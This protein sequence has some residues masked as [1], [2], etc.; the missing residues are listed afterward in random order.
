[1][2]QWHNRV[3]EAMWRKGKTLTYGGKSFDQMEI[4]LAVD[5]GM[6]VDDYVLAQM[7]IIRDAHGD[8]S[9][10]PKQFKW[11][12]NGSLLIPVYF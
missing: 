12:H 4:K 1:M 6:T 11:T 9:L 8:Y 3:E 7:E 5:V 10:N 2:D